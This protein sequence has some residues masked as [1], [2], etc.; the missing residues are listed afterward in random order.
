MNRPTPDPRQPGVG[1]LTPEAPD[2]PPHL[3]LTW[4]FSYPHFSDEETEV[5][6]RK[7]TC[8]ETTGHHRIHTEVGLM[9][10]LSWAFP[11]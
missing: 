3:I 7:I 10:R 6:N 5:Q 11:W 2:C 8:L 1:H 4:H 9:P